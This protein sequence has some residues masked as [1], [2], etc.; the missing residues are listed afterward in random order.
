MQSYWPVNL[1][2]DTV[3]INYSH[4]SGNTCYRISAKVQENQNLKKIKEKLYYIA[5]KK[6][7]KPKY[8]SYGVRDSFYSKFIY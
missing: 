1:S 6:F 4:K 3:Q 8:G 7:G 5:V 2:F